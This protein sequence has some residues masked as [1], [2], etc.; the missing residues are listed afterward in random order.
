MKEMISIKPHHFVDIITLLGAGKIFAPHPYK[1]DLHRVAYDIFVN[2]DILVRIELGADDIC[3]PCIHN[4]NGLCDDTIDTSYRPEA[5]SLKREWNL[6]IDNRW[7]E[8]LKLKQNDILS[9][10]DFCQWLQNLAG[11]ISSIYQEIPADRTKKREYH[12]KEGIR[13]FLSS[14]D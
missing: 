4:I 1:H 6:L 13:M 9:A 2:H 11:D 10:R 7:C 5:P 3:Q 8:R 14:E 12:L